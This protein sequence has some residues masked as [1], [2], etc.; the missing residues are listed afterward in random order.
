[1]H[2]L[3]WKKVSVDH[4]TQENRLSLSCS[5]L[6][7][8]MVCYKPVSSGNIKATQPTRFWLS[9][10]AHILLAKPKQN[11][12]HKLRQNCEQTHQ[13]A[14]KL[15]FIK[16]SAI[17]CIHWNPLD[18]LNKPRQTAAKPLMDFDEIWP[19]ASL[20]LIIGQYSWILEPGNSNQGL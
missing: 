12:S 5:M 10:F 16:I 18:S 13:I 15:T 2:R 8:H 11:V 1:M 17:S 14:L 3:N 4:L 20:S 9:K 7:H 6:I 19:S